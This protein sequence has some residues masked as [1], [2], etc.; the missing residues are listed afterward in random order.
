MRF[1]SIALVFIA[2]TAAL[3]KSQNG[4]QVQSVHTSNPTGE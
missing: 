2:A 4:W 3:L 1:L